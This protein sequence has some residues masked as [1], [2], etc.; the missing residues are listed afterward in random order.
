MR[1]RANKK[2]SR[3][4]D[5]NTN[6]NA[7]A[8]TNR[9]RTKNNMSPFPSV[10]DINTYSQIEIKAYFHFSHYKSMET[11]SCHSIENTWAT[12]IKN[13]IDVKVYIINIYIYEKFQLRP[14]YGF[15]EEDFWIFISKI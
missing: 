12:A 1:Y 2:V 13:T 15:W 8:D 4:A 5:T 10:G 14:H 3:D 9:I 6:A 11:L 7:N